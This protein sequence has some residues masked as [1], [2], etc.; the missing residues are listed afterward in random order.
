MAANATYTSNEFC[1]ATASAFATFA[2][3]AADG[4]V[5]AIENV[6]VRIS[7]HVG[8]DLDDI[9][10]IICRSFVGIRELLLYCDFSADEFIVSEMVSMRVFRATAPG[11]GTL[12]L[13]IVPQGSVN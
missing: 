2:S 11:P 1:F 10:Q 4:D 12:S 3:Q 7:R 6:R 5:A 9:Q 8:K 13:C